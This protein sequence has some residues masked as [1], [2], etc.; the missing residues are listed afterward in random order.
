LNKSIP[1]AFGLYHD[2]IGKNPNVES[3]PAK[4]IRSENMQYS[5]SNKKEHIRVFL[6]G[7]WNGSTW[8]NEMIEYLSQFDIDYFNPVV[9]NWDDEARK[10]ERFEKEHYCDY[11]LYVITPKMKGFYS[12]A[13]VVDESNKQPE[14]T[15]FVWLENDEN[16]HFDVEQIMSLRSVRNLLE[17]NGVKCF[18]NLLD[19]ACWMG[20][21]K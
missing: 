18:N 1:D 15:L 6:G 19:C 13:E 11:N 21:Q 3:R 4:T 2:R 10:I 20:Q 8:R 17:R 9:D 12:I 7:T 14:K 16:C 5:L